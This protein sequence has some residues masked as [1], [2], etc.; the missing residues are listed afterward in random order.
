[1]NISPL[2]IVLVGILA[3]LVS[4][5]GAA[6]SGASAT[7]PATTAISQEATAMPVPTAA[8]EIPATTVP[9][10]A[11]TSA[12]ATANIPQV[13]LAKQD[14]VVQKGLDV[15]AITVV[16]VQEQQWNDSSLGCAQPDTAYMQVITPGYLITLEAAGST[17]AY[18]TDTDARVVLCEDSKPAVR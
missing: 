7:P 17:Y 14:L 12:P 8:L 3:L 9:A 18:H 13:E 5:C 6:P 2:R 4:A 16:D 11:P 1:M 10:T 15:A